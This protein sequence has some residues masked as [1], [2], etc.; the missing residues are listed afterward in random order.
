MRTVIDPFSTDEQLVDKLLGSSYNNILLMLENIEVVQH[1][2]A[3]LQEVFNVSNNIEQV[4]F[5]GNNIANIV[6]VGDMAPTI[7]SLATNQASLV[8]LSN[9][10][11]EVLGVHAALPSIV[12][13]SGGIA[14]V[15][16]VATNIA[17]VTTVSTELV[18]LAAVGAKLAELTAIF[19]N[20]TVLTE[21][22]ANLESG[23]PSPV[24]LD[25]GTSLSLTV[26][27]SG[28]YIRRSN[29][30]ANTITFTAQATAAWE[31]NIEVH[32]RNA[33]AGQLTL[34]ADAGVTLNIAAGGGLKLNTGMTVTVK[35]VGIDQWDVLGQ[36]VV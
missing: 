1:V 28:S 5:I 17:T 4:E 6:I 30:A 2:S 23:L 34:V 12:T 25:T 27:D 29:A 7:T 26:L 14:E 31:N 16:T 33:G 9:E 3:H 36:T 8:A 22:A 24:V 18:M 13:V 19:D 11:T 21:L 15:G 32:I 10:L 35:R 20:L